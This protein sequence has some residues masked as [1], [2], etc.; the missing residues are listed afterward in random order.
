MANE[1]RLTINYSYSNNGDTFSLSDSLN[2]SLLSGVAGKGYGNIQTIPSGQSVAIN[3]GSLGNVRYIALNNQSTGNFGIA[4]ATNSG[5][6]SGLITLQSGD[7]A[8]FPPTTSGIWASGVSGAALLG[9]L[10]NEA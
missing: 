4:L 3:F 10:G 2:Y 9:V 7:F 8:I 5:Q 6:I 1:V